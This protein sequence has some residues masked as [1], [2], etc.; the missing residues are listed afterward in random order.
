MLTSTSEEAVGLGAG[1][2][3]LPC[4]QGSFLFGEDGEVCEAG[5]PRFFWT[6]WGALVG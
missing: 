3:E 2:V 6:S 5:R 4:T 1:D